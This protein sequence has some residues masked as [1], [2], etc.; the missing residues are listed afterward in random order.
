MFPYAFCARTVDTNYT[1]WCGVYKKKKTIN[2]IFENDLYT[3][4]M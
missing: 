4:P 3:L 2:F 1:V